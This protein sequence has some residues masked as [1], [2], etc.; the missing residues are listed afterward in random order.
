MSNFSKKEGNTM[1]YLVTASEGPGFS[2]PEEDVHI[3]EKT[4][5]PSF[6]ALIELEKGK[7]I[8]GGGLPLG[9]KS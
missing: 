5:L 6:E 8:L 4:I 7:K 9:D 3:L 2:S 1:R